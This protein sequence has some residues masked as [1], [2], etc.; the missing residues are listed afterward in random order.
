MLSRPG[1]WAASSRPWHLTSTEL[2][3]VSDKIKYRPKHCA[4]VQRR[5]ERHQASDYNPESFLSKGRKRMKVFLSHSTKDKEFVQRLAAALEAADFEPLAL[6]GRYRPGRE[7]RCQDQPRTR[8]IGP[9]ASGLVARRGQVRLDGTGMDLT[10]G[11][12]GGG[13][14]DS[15]GHHTT[16]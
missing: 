8:A 4:L 14:Q 11:A 13:T 5:L 10:A 15:S 12:T 9:G 3:S 6:R 7:L 16:A 2:P 1:N